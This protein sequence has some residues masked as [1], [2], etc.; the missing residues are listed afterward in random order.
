MNRLDEEKLIQ[1]V[2]R[3]LDASIAQLPLLTQQHL[4]ESRQAALLQK[5]H[6]GSQGVD[7]LAHAVGKELEDS[8]TLSPDIEARLDQIRHNAVAK[9][10]QQREQSSERSGF[11][12]FSWIKSQVESFNFDASAGMLATACVLVTAISIFYVNSRPTGT[13]TLEEEIGLVA[14]AEDIELYENLEFY[15]WLAENE[16]LTL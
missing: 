5:A 7:E 4:T 10:E 8:S 2:C 16:S 6:L 1:E 11:S 9:F 13:L 15:L 12:L 14:T 3:Y